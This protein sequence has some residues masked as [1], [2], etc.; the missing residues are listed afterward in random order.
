MHAEEDMYSG[1]LQTIQMLI[2]MELCAHRHTE[3]G[4]HRAMY[5]HVQIQFYRT[6]QYYT[7]YTHGFSPSCMK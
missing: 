5:A 7:E 3:S 2:A 6:E 4:E 1:L